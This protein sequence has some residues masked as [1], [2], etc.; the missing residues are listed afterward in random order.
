[1]RGCDRFGEEIS[2]YLDG[3]LSPS[4]RAKFDAHLP[5]CDACGSGL[6]AQRTLGATLVALPRVEPS[7]QFEARFWARLARDDRRPAWRLRRLAPLAWGVG[8]ALV[9]ALAISIPSRGPEIAP[10]DWDLVVDADF[11]LF[12]AEDQDLIA[13]LDVLEAWDGSE[14]I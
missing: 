5:G 8:A 10:A 6:A 3:E 9:V 13:A 14:D 4:S 12:A 1:M 7:P 11:E 2:A